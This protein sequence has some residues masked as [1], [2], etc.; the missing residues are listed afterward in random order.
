MYQ[1]QNEEV[2]EI[3]NKIILCAVVFIFVMAL[4]LL[5]VFNRFG[6][7]VNEVLQALYQKESFVVFFQN[8]SDKCPDCSMV[9]DTLNE[10]GVSYYRFDV[11]VS[12]Y[13]EVLQLLN[14]NYK[15]TLPAVYVIED[16]E[17]RYNITNITDR[18][19]VVSFVEN[20]DVALFS[21]QAE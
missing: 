16:G 6:S 3:K 19:T 2:Q 5:L 1:R 21:N 14:I 12:S 10:L 15:I 9:E 13:D 17:V 18:D 4:G 11:D 20:N 7:D 8:D